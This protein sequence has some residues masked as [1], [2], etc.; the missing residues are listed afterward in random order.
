MDSIVARIGSPVLV[1]NSFDAQVLGI[2]PFWVFPKACL[3]LWE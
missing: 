2:C 1:P 3:S